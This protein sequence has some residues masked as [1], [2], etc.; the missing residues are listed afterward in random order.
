MPAELH[1]LILR[2]FLRLSGH[3]FLSTMTL[4][5]PQTSN[6]G[7]EAEPRRVRTVHVVDADTA[8]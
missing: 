5:V 3:Y 7:F 1:D 2:S 8:A 4:R 6:I